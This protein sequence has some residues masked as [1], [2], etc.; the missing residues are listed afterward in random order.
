VYFSHRFCNLMKW[1]TVKIVRIIKPSTYITPVNG[2]ISRDKC[3]GTI[4][5]FLIL[6]HSPDFLFFIPLKGVLKRVTGFRE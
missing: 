6:I 2:K 3:L 5:K 1:L 4:F